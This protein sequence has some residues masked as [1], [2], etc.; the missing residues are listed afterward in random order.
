M[1][2]DS[3]SFTH[4]QPVICPK[5]GEKAQRVNRKLTDRFISLFAMVKRYRC[6]VCDWNGTIRA[7]TAD[8]KA[9]L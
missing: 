6:T 5:C 2:T 1:G 9:V 8:R 3:Q 4:K 7:N